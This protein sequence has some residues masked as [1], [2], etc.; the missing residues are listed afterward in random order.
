MISWKDI[1]P[2][3]A[4]VIAADWDPAEAV[5]MTKLAKAILTSVN[6]SAPLSALDNAITFHQKALY[7]R[8][9]RHSKRVFSLS[10][11]AAALYARHRRTG[12]VPNLDQAIALLRE[13]IEGCP[14][15]DTCRLDLLL[16]LSAVLSARFDLTYQHLDMQE[17][18]E[19][20]GD[21]V[22]ISENNNKIA[23]WLLISWASVEVW[24]VNVA[25][26][27]RSSRLSIS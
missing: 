27:P 2:E 21:A 1:S 26:K 5:E 8:P 25:Y 7:L 18:M 23:G 9:S 14:K 17:A 4:G 20:Y 19:R 13:A 6:H 12:S 3:Y 10:G 16:K 24:Q 15:P 22:Q 11:L